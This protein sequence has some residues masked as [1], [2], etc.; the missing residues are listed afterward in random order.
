M[1]PV[2]I[3]HIWRN[4]MKEL[5]VSEQEIVRIKYNLWER[6]TIPQ[7]DNTAKQAKSPN[8]IRTF[9][10]CPIPTKPFAMSL[11]EFCRDVAKMA[12][13]LGGMI[14]QIFMS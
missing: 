7:S 9:F 6:I 12:F 8:A 14:A 13:C 4:A 5:N 11:M 3:R 10:S 2:C 1:Y